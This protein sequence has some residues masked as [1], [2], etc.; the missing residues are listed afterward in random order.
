MLQNQDKDNNQKTDCTIAN[1]LFGNVNYNRL[2]TDQSA[3]AKA[4]AKDISTSKESPRRNQNF[5][6]DCWENGGKKEI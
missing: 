1:S 2:I 5:P 6:F 4:Q 3:K